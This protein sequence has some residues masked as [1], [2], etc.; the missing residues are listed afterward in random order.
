MNASRYMEHDPEK[1]WSGFPKRPCSIKN[2]KRDDDL[3]QISS[4]FTAAVLEQVRADFNRS[5]SVIRRGRAAAIL[6]RQLRWLLPHG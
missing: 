6:P 5:A 3:S 2:L 1:G 4:R